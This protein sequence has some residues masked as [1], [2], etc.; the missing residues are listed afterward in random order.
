MLDEKCLYTRSWYF[1]FALHVHTCREI[2]SNAK[3]QCL[4]CLHPFLQ[5]ALDLNPN[6]YTAI[7]ARRRSH[8][9]PF[10]TF[11]TKRTWYKSEI[12]LTIQYSVQSNCLIKQDHSHKNE[13]CSCKF[14]CSICFTFQNELII[15]FQ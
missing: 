12:V 10:L 13:V 3:T 9:V 15:P 6:N 2:S 5:G 7:H 14:G 1:Q 4:T 8:E 11:N